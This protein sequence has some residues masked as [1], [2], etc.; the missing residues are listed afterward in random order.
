MKKIL[1][2]LILSLLLT[3][4]TS[5]SDV[6]EIETV[7]LQN[8]E[9]FIMDKDSQDANV[10]LDAINKKDKTNEN[11]TS[12]PN[13]EIKL[14]KE[15]DQEVYKLYFDLDNKT[16]YLSQASN[17]Y[18]VKDSAAKKLFLSNVFS[19]IYIDATIYYSYLDL[20]GKKLSPQ[21]EYS[22]NSKNID[23]HFINNSGT[24][25]E[26]YEK[27]NLLTI[28][29]F[30]SIELIYEKEPDS[31]TVKVYSEDK[32]I[33][34]GTNFHDVISNIKDDG[35]YLVECHSQWHSKEGLSYYGNQ[36][37]R[38]DALVDR[39]ASLNIITKE[40]SPGNILL[41][42]VENLNEDETI[43]ISTDAVKIENDIYTYKDK[44]YYMF[45]IDL[46]AQPGDYALFALVNQ[47]ADN[48]YT[49]ETALTVANKSFKTQYLTVSQ[50]MN[51]T[52]ND[53]T[54]I[55]EFV[56]LVKPARTESSKEKL[57]EGTFIMPVEGRLTT[58]FAEIRYVNNEPSSSRHSGLDLA[59]P[60]GTPVV[61]PNN[62]IV[63]F[64]MEGLLSPG[65]TVV[66]DHG[67]GLFTSYYHLDT[68][69]VE[70]G[71]EVNKGSIIGSVGSTGFSTGPHLHYAVSIYNTYVNPYQTLS[72]I[73]DW[74]Q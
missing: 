41:I 56:Q 69:D 9:N 26:K 63:T 54:A 21:I 2:I 5:F 38:F 59:A 61:A 53:N 10:I 1:C 44:N 58:D 45:P 7:N 55:Y 29:Q 62:G 28:S 70:K 51:E 50:E 49:L 64:A 33:S 16:V 30:E 43:K 19:Y 3:A 6:I 47:G 42:S 57:W 24:L 34:S 13:Y 37:I 17:L 74:K 25:K 68:I 65:N 67:M 8:G 39:P 48:E 36:T 22:W 32:I 18:K 27:A 72:G 31:Q 52:N 11:V 73:I 35:Q 15:N 60:T 71:Q 40:N 46:Y 66:I 4:C 12:L 23:G 20:G 14:I